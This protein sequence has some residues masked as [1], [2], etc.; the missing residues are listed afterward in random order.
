MGSATTQALAATTSALGAASSVDLGVARELFAAAR[1]MGESAQLR[2][3]LADSAAAPAARAKVVA[4][5]FGSFQPT[6]VSLLTSAV[7]QRWSSASD[8]VDGIEELGIRATAI[9]EPG[10]DIEGE[11]FAVIRTIAANPELELALGSR[12]GDASAK[13]ALVETLLGGRTSA[14]TTLIVSSAVQQTRERRVRQLLGRA[15][16]LVAQQR[17]RSVAT[18][19]AAKPLGAGQADRLSAALSQR[20]GTDISLNVV[21]DPSVVGGLR[22][23]IADDVIDASV[24]SRLND[25]RQKLAG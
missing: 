20:Y 11:L 19:V 18:V 23:E 8:L 14:G 3:A 15:M 10:S 24:S 2:G 6:T 5:V 9:A 12:L 17:G 1:A 16:R 25:L 13:G 21:V 22:V 7:Q 4:H